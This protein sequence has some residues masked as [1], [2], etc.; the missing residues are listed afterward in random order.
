M[1]TTKKATPAKAKPDK[2]S[3]MGVSYDIEY[4]SEMLDA[5]IDRRRELLGQIDYN[6]R[7]IRLYSKNEKKPNGDG[8]TFHLLIHEMIHAIALNAGFNF[9]MGDEGEPIVDLFAT[10]LADTLVRNDM[11]TKEWGEL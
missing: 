3:V 4:V 8:Y 1:A 9:L 2:I 5:D 7:T 11:V 6:T 10:V